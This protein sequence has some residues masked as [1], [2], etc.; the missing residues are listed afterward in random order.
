[1]ALSS[2]SRPHHLL[3][4]LFRGFHATEQALAR[5]KPHGFSKPHSLCPRSSASSTV[6]ARRRSAYSLHRRHLQLQLGIPQPQQQQLRLNPLRLIPSFIRDIG[7]KL[8][9]PQVT[10]ATATV[11][12]H[13]FYL[14]Q[15]HAKNER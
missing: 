2:S 6:S 1:M 10:N 8:H 7:L 12:F 15:S 5:P 9:L 3:C 11:F 13:R 14:R 4:P